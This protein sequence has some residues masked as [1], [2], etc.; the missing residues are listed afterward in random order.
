[1]RAL[2]LGGAG[3]LGHKLWQQWHNRYEVWVTVRSRYQEYAHLGLFSSECM[4][5]GV[6][7][8]DFDSVVNAIAKV[9]PEVVINCI[10]V[11]KQLH[12]ANDPVCCLTVN[13]LFPHRLASVCRAASA[14]MIHISTDC[15]FSGRKGM[16]LESDVPDAEDLYG[17]TK[18]L[19]E[20]AEA[21]CLTLRTSIIGR[22][23][24]SQSGLLEWFLSQRGKR[25]K[26]YG[27][28]IYSG[29][30][31]L[32]FSRILSDILEHHKGLEGLYQVSSE[33]ISKYALLEMI[34]EGCGLDVEIQLDEEVSVNRS[35]DSSRFRAET[36]FRPPD[37]PEMVG[38][39]C[40]D[41]TPY[42]RWKERN[43][44]CR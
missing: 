42:D 2:L 32:A 6:D 39:M 30:T 37:W 38:E 29:F 28:A 43:D 15:V 26:G 21:G 20:V 11:I 22:E 24:A 1:M 41:P 7:V 3:M 40:H 14:R 34:R 35:L 33:P 23:L 25:V 5:G 44:L 36:G 18:H 27:N 31:T 19:G 16:Y 17:R 4:L 10:G 8:A 12:A 13:S 9:H